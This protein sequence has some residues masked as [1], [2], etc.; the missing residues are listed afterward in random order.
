MKVNF[1]PFKL[2]QL[3]LFL[4]EL[5]FQFVMV[6]IIGIHVLGIPLHQVSV[7]ATFEVV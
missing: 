6:K 7:V 1:P 5:E 3:E 2:V 4:Q